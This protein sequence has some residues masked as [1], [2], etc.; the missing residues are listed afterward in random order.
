M[1]ATNEYRSASNGLRR[2]WRLA[3]I[4]GT[5]GALALA[6]LLA[7]GW[8]IQKP[9]DVISNVETSIAGIAI[10]TSALE[11]NYSALQTDQQTMLR[12]L[13]L[14]MTRREAQFAGVCKEYPT[15]DE[16]ARAIR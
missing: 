2:V 11:R 1:S 12:M 14:G 16:L 9:G 3:E 5:V 7:M 4:V 15:R 10:R 6:A 8:K 13:C